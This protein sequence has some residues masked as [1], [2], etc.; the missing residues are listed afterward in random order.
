MVSV[1]VVVLGDIAGRSVLALTTRR[2][3]SMVVQ[4]SG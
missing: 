4:A 3:L 2:T 1:L